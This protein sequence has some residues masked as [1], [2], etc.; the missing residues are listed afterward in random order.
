[1]RRQTNRWQGISRKLNALRGA[2]A[3]IALVSLFINVLMLTGPMFML[4]VY[5]RVLASGSVPTLVVLGGLTAALFLFYGLLD[6]LR[7]RALLRIGQRVDTQLSGEAFEISTLAPIVVGQKSGQVR[8]VQDIDGLRTFLSGP[9]PSAIFDLPWMPL[10]LAVVFLFHPLLGWFAFSGGLLLCILIALKEVFSRRPSKEAAQ[11]ATRRS[12]FVEMARANAEAIQ[13][14]GMLARL[15]QQWSKQNQEYLQ[16]QRSSNDV[17]NLFSTSTKT[18][19]FLMQSGILGLGAWLAIQ[20]Q[21][22]PGIMIAASIMMSRALAPIE[23]AVAHWSSLVAARQS[24][25]RLKQYIEG[26]AADPD[27]L[28]ITRPKHKLSV[29]ALNCAPIGVN[30]PYVRNISFELKS[31]DGLGIIGPSGSGK[32]TLARAI[33]GI[34]SSLQGSVRLDGSTLDQWAAD[35]RSSFVGYL[36]QDVQLLDGTIAQNI[37]RFAEEADDNL[38]VEAARTADVHELIASLPDGYN[39]LIGSGGYGLSAGQRQRVALARAIYDNPFLVVLDEPNSNLDAD[40]EAALSNA[41]K[42]IRKSGSIVVVVAHR[43]SAIA[44]VDKILCMKEGL[45]TNFGPKEEVLRQSLAPVADRE[46]G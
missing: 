2:F 37:S 23:Q 10:Y 21:V 12:G 26:R 20:Q 5:D 41:I 45:Q 38:V 17:T 46:A 29:E 30:V 43:P 4:Q 25:Q 28:N 6:G 42:S 39:T 27:L 13:S 3:G 19:R 7:G 15:R 34:T 1:M 22:S 35:V 18:V 8:P 36:P 9:G 14:M 40:G 32:S 16:K 44:S 11:E 33:V 31:G 24:Y